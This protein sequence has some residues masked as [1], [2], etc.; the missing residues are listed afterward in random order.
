MTTIHAVLYQEAKEGKEQGG[1]ERMN[2]LG[3]SSDQLEGIR[4]DTLFEV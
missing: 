3:V 4:G 1:A 2:L